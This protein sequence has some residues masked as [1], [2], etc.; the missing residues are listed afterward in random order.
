MSLVL[1]NLQVF[2]YIFVMIPITL[3]ILYQVIRFFY[4]LF[5]WGT[6]ENAV[7]ESILNPIVVGILWWAGAILIL[8]D[9]VGAAW[10]VI[11]LLGIVVFGMA[12][13]IYGRIIPQY[14]MNISPF[15]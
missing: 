8:K 5:E 11:L 14:L 4:G 12:F 15:F 2:G 6:F 9:K 7:I 1:K 10:P 3:F 13:I